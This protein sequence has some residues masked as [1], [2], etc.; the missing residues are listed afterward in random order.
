M[1]D[2]LSRL[3]AAGFTPLADLFECSTFSIHLVLPADHQTAALTA[4]MLEHMLRLRSGKP[5]AS[6]TGLA[7]ML[8]MFG[9]HH[10][11]QG[12]EYLAAV[13]RGRNPPF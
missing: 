4:D 7:K 6:A 5:E 11:S 12:A 1:L 10:R 8:E 2:W 3:E 9:K 13:L